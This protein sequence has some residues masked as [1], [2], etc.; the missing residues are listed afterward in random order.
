[1]RSR[2]NKTNETILLAGLLWFAE[3]EAKRTM[4]ILAGASLSLDRE[5]RKENP[6][7]AKLNSLT[8]RVD[9]LVK[10]VRDCQ[11]IEKAAERNLK[12]AS[13]RAE[14]TPLDGPLRTIKVGQ[15]ETVDFEIDDALV[16][17]AHIKGSRIQLRN[18]FSGG[19]QLTVYP[20]AQNAIEIQP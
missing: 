17:R 10:A 5:R 8:A 14:G 12:K 3:H 16:L 2:I 1:M 4:L 15:N 18:G 19:G 9:A 11:K 6:S 20:L 13:K 7:P